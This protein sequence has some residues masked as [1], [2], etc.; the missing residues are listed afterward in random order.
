[1]DEERCQLCGREG[2][3]MTRHHLIPRTLHSNKWFRERYKRE[4]MRQVVEL[5]KDCHITIHQFIKER[6]MGR[7]FNTLEKLMAHEKIANW[8]QWVANR[9][10]QF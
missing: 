10:A 4:V 6:E 9:P 1:M 3:E 8:V 7:N 5:C 2:L